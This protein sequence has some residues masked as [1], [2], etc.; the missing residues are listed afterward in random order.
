MLYLWKTTWECHSHILWVLT[1]Q[2]LTSP[3]FVFHLQTQQNCHGYWQKARRKEHFTGEPCTLSQTDS[4]GIVCEAVGDIYESWFSLSGSLL[5]A[6]TTNILRWRSIQLK[7]QPTVG[8]GVSE[9]ISLCLY[10]A[11]SEKEI[12]NKIPLI[13]RILNQ[14]GRLTHHMKD[15]SVI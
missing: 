11:F 2:T 3:L 9:T 15:K 13:K 6:C 8:G 14:V 5:L 7:V 1:W 12:P 4:S 10:A